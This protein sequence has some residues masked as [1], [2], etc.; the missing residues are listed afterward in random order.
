M[1]N[2]SLFLP[3]S[4]FLCFIV[5]S[6]SS[7][8]TAFPERTSSAK[9][10]NAALTIEFNAYSFPLDSCAGPDTSLTVCSSSPAFDLLDLVDPSAQGMG[11]WQGSGGSG[12]YIFNPSM[13]QLGIYSFF[14]DV[15]CGNGFVA[16]S[17]ITILVTN[18]PAGDDYPPILACA[19]IGANYEVDLSFLITLMNGQPGGQFSY[20]GNP[21]YMNGMSYVNGTIFSCDLVG[22]YE[23]IYVVETEA[24]GSDTSFIQ[25]TLVDPT[26]VDAGPDI[27]VCCADLIN[28]GVPLL[29]QSVGEF[30]TPEWQTN[31]DGVFLNP[32]SLNTSYFPGPID[33]QLGQVVLSLQSNDFTTTCQSGVYN[34]FMLL[35]LLEDNSHAGPNDFVCG[36][37]SY[38]LQ[39]QQDSNNSISWSTLGDGSFS[40]I[41]DPNATYTAGPGD[42]AT[43]SAD[44]IM[45]ITGGPCGDYTDTVSLSFYPLDHPACVAD[46]TGYVFNDLDGDGMMNGADYGLPLQTVTIEPGGL[47]AI[48]NAD[49]LFYFGMLTAGDY[50][51]NLNPDTLF[52]FNTTELAVSVTVGMGANE[53]IYFGISHELDFFGSNV[54]LY[55]ENSLYNCDLFSPHDIFFRNLSNVPV[56]VVIEL[57]YD[58]LFQGYS[59]V[60]PIDSAYNHT[61]WMSVQDLGPGQLTHLEVKLH[62]P[63]VDNFGAYLSS[64]ARSRSYADGLEVHSSETVLEQQ[65]ACAYDPN[66]KQVFPNG[67]SEAH[68]IANDTILEYLIRFQNTGNA[69]A[70]HVIIR[71]TLDVNLDLSTFQLV[72]NSHSVFTTLDLNTREVEFYFQSIMLPDSVNNEPESHGLVSFKIRPVAGLPL[73]TEL[74]NTAAIYFDNNPPIV[75]NTTWSTIYDCSLFEASFSQNEFLLTASEGDSYQWYKNSQPISGANLQELEITQSAN[76]MVEIG[77]AFPCIDSS[78]SIFIEGILPQDYI[79]FPDSIA[80]WNVST[81]YLVGEFNS[82]S[83]GS[84]YRM[85]GDSLINDSLYSLL[86]KRFSWST[87]FFTGTL[88]N[89]DQPF[90]LIGGVRE[91]N[92]GKVWFRSMTSNNEWW[93]VSGSG[94]FFDGS[95]EYLMYDFGLQIGDSI[96]VYVD[97]GPEPE[98]ATMY[99]IYTD[100]L[101]RRTYK[102][103]RGFSW[104]EPLI[105][106]EGIGSLYGG[107]L[108]IYQINQNELEFGNELICFQVN[109]ELIYSVGLPISNDCDQLLVSLEELQ[110][111]LIT[112]FPNPMTET[113][114]L[115]LGELRGPIQVEIYDITGKLLRSQQLTTNNQQLT[116]ERGNLRKGN[117]L[118]RLTH[119]GEAINVK[120]AVE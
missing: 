90:I 31:G 65:L 88:S 38:V 91:D 2:S 53:P 114:I 21:Q 112:L 15:D 117:Y 68:Y 85:E 41:T 48:T 10:N 110:T 74:N 81:S 97:G 28:F 76:Y 75:T 101:E 35:T 98:W 102:L 51:I 16:T 46:I 107:P 49:G 89:S 19:N 100:I 45:S 13:M 95:S 77:S 120:F 54:V 52:P 82:A 60:S 71:D 119:E 83:H 3:L 9:E 106:T 96:L 87:S 94:I 24:C 116:L 58:S 59:E 5:L 55:A 17:S 43:M 57:E 86:Y 4:A 70:T 40:D 62:T 27:T 14:Y 78:E 22:Q 36:E 61:I 47:S 64:T 12:S 50:I 99:E 72:A 25:I 67:Y 56:D 39:G 37:N 29:G 20:S 7:S 79:P 84:T 73:L 80:A 113:A 92:S 115:D 93:D 103:Q 109:D 32:F 66:D 34:D 33:C 26:I 108:S 69:P 18:D 118:L 23:F 44:L 11:I 111:S 105:W 6:I 63:T 104:S 8:A 1:K 30:S 42:L